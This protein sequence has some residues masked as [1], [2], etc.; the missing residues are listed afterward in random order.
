VNKTNPENTP[1]EVDNIATRALLQDKLPEGG[2]SH[3]ASSDT[4]DRG[5][6]G[7]ITMSAKEI[8]CGWLQ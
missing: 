7:A 2:N 6:T 8:F 4:S 3:T 1:V 5:E